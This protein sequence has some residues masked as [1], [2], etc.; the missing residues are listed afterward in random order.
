[1]LKLAALAALLVACTDD[2]TP[3]VVSCDDFAGD[4]LLSTYD[5]L[6][7][8][9]RIAP[10]GLEFAMGDRGAPLIRWPDSQQPIDAAPDCEPWNGGCF[11]EVGLNGNGWVYRPPSTWTGDPD[12]AGLVVRTAPVGDNQCAWVRCE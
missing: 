5:S 7:P 3:E 8:T 6:S 12:W 10:T 1:M 2:T 11:V 9:C 4:A